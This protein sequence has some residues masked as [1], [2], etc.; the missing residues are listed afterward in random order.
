MTARFMVW[1]VI[2]QRD[3]NPTHLG[4]VPNKRGKTLMSRRTA[5]KTAEAYTAKHGRPAFAQRVA[6]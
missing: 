4:L 6:R 5:Q 1:E 2:A 3:D